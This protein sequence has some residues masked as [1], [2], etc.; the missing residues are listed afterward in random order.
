MTTTYQQFV[1]AGMKKLKNRDLT[2]QQKMSLIARQWR[3]SKQ[4]SGALKLKGGGDKR[5]KKKPTRGS[6]FFDDVG[7]FAG[8]YVDGLL[9]RG[10]T[11][12][13]KPKKKKAPA[14]KKPKTKKTATKGKGMSVRDTGKLSGQ[15]A[16]FGVCGR[17]G[18][19]ITTCPPRHSVGHGE[20]PPPAQKCPECHRRVDNHRSLCPLNPCPHCGVSLPI[21]TAR[22]NTT[23]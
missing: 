4:G 17:A 13:K 22:H 3:A 15:I 14:K 6:G 2:P 20:S 16:G 19:Y 5:T 1:K 11:K 8:G 10:A 18:Y 12:P 9:G 23:I 7:D 21:T